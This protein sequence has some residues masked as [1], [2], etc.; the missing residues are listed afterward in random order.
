MSGMLLAR[1]LGIGPGNR[2]PL[3]EHLVGDT[4]FEPVSG[5]FCVTGSDLR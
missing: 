5:T 2:L 4:G 1:N 3:G